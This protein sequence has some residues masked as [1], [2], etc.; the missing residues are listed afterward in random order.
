VRIG[1][2]LR[3]TS[4][5]PATHVVHAERHRAQLR[6]ARAK[7]RQAQVVRASGGGGS[8]KRKGVGVTSAVRA[9]K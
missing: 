4:D 7:G 6:H 1:Q 2:K 9:E 5:V 8:G 3:V